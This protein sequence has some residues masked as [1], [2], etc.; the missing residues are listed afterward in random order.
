MI[1]K[2]RD[3]ILK[4]KL[5]I[6][7]CGD[8]GV[9]LGA[10]LSGREF[11]LF[12]LRRS[13]GRLPD[14][15]Q[16][17]ACDLNDHAAVNAVLDQNFDY[18]VVTLTPDQYNEQSYRQTYVTNLT[19]VLNA[20]SDT[21][22]PP[23]HLLFVSSTSVYGQNQGEWV[24]EESVT[25]PENYRGRTMLEAENLCSS[26]KLST[27][28]IRFSGIYGPGRDR[29]T[30]EVREG[31]WSRQDQQWTNRIHSEDAAGVLAWCLNRLTGN[32]PL[33][34]LYL[35]SDCEPAQKDL[36]CAWMA[37]RLNAPAPIEVVDEQENNKNLNKRCSSKRLQEAGFQFIYP[38]FREGYQL[39]QGRSK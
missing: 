29:L 32:Q 13:V 11:S 30:R 22:N 10:R 34:R 37:A 27:T 5:L 19:I 2:S 28:I 33:D 36:V 25:E 17:L 39:I 24:D 6:V 7:G 26:S 14:N 9:R 23:R 35:A 4:H 3:T 18:V 31:R 15:I 16:P 8:L 12:G 20:L 38:S 21:K 1:T